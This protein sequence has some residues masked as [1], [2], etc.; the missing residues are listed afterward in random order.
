M[1]SLDNF[2][3]LTFTK[4]KAWFL[5][6]HLHIYHWRLRIIDYVLHVLNSKIYL[7]F[8]GKGIITAIDPWICRAPIKRNVA[9]FFS[10]TEQIIV[11]IKEGNAF[12]LTKTPHCKFWQTVHINW[13][14]Y[15]F[16]NKKQISFTLKMN[17]NIQKTVNIH[18]PKKKNRVW[19]VHLRNKP[20]HQF[21]CLTGFVKFQ[22]W[23]HM[24]LFNIILK[25]YRDD[26]LMFKIRFIALS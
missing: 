22:T 8:N 17:R 2:H 11:F 26:R 13:Y 20:K 10:L 1:F 14:Y 12:S 24:P 25:E 6:V 16:S 4:I 7:H 23:N 15:S 9:F 3:A 19:N 5:D 21:V 18:V